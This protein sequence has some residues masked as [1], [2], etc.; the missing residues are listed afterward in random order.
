MLF[1]S[2]GSCGLS[3]WLLPA[4]FPWACR[5]QEVLMVPEKKQTLNRPNDQEL[6]RASGPD[7]DPAYLIGNGR[8]VPKDTLKWLQALTA[9]SKAGNTLAQGNTAF[10]KRSTA[11]IVMNLWSMVLKIFMTYWK[12]SSRFYG[13]IFMLGWV[14]LISVYNYCDW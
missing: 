9:T 11:V 13:V 10:Y 14:S 1:S 6:W 5:W 7:S 8:H 4:A 12:I 2:K 3:K